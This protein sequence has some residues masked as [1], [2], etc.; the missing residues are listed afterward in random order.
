MKKLTGLPVGL[1]LLFTGLVVNSSIAMAQQMSGAG[2]PPPPVLV[3]QREVLKPG[4]AGSTHLK[5]E[6]AFVQAMTAAKWPTH[7]FAA[8]SLS[9]VPR[10]LFFIGYPSFAAWEKDNQDTAKNTTL[11]AAFDR[12]SFVDGEQL[13]DFSTGVFTFNEESSLHANIDIAHMRYFEISQFKVRPGHE[14]DWTDLV[15]MYKSTFEKAVP[16]AQWAIFDS[17]YGHENGGLHLVFVPMKSLAEVDAHMADDKKFLAA[18]GEKGMQKL[19]ELSAACIESE[20]TNVFQF[21][22]KMSYPAEEWI[23]EDPGFWKPKMAA[24][25]KKAATP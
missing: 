3:I 10:A 20:Q 16:D 8:E 4:R 25:P 1:C 12:A 9:G 18:L 2:T 19:G 17:M 22:P 23:K 11:S 13:S 6:S 21:N 14:K 24:A 15:K 5:T 7:Y